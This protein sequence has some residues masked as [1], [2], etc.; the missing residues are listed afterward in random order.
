LWQ[1]R[2]VSGGI[3]S[4]YTASL[5]WHISLN[6]KPILEGEGVTPTVLRHIKQRVAPF[7][8]VVI[9]HQ[10][11]GTYCNGGTFWFLGLKRDGAYQ[12]S[13]GIGECFAQE[14]VVTVGRNSVKV[15]VRGGYGNNRLPEEPYLPGG[16]WL[17]QNGR[18]TK[19]KSRRS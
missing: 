6:D 16:T 10:P 15:T 19:I 2:T 4:V 3:G 11:E 14:P 13:Q 9:L 8:E 17:Y 1:V 18:V 12:L 7:D 5:K